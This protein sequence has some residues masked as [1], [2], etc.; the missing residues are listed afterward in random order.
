MSRSVVNRGTVRCPRC[1]LAPRWCICAGYRPIPDRLAV[2]VLIH[3]RESRRPTST[4]MLLT[5]I[6]PD[7]RRHLFQPG[8]APDAS[9]I[10][11]P[12]KTLWIL[13][14]TG[15]ELP[16]TP[17]P[18]ELQVLLL[19]GSWPESVRM[20]KKVESWGRRVRLPPSNT[21]RYRLRSQHAEGRSST[22]GALLRL[23]EALGLDDMAA[24]LRVQLDLHIYAGLRSRGAL[25]EAEELLATSPL[26]DAL[27]EVLRALKERRR[28][29]PTPG[30]P[31]APAPGPD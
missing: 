21:D 22:A 26:P 7:V 27:P 18:G 5:R 3:L 4:G 2:D 6:L 11:R 20:R 16:S 29:G 13:D 14:P 17:S 31:P 25:R 19:D 15:D 9:S 12:G 8:V 28:C 24:A 1:L 23:V 30:T 10:V